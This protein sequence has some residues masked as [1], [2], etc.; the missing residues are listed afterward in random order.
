MVQ[1]LISSLKRGQFLLKNS[2]KKSQKQMFEFKFYLGGSIMFCRVGTIR[3]VHQQLLTNGYHV[4][5]YAIRKW[6]QDGTLP[7]VRSG[8]KIFITY[9]HVVEFLTTG[10]VALEPVAA[11]I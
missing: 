5:E 1:K 11:S 2:S 4:T 10:T 8:K 3:E 9:D 6:V 7:S